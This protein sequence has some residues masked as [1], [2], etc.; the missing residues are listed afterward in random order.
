LK[1]TFAI[2]SI[3]VAASLYNS[4]YVVTECTVIISSV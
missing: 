3:D 1:V 4:S 2:L